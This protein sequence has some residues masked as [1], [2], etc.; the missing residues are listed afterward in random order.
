MTRRQKVNKVYSEQVS[1]KHEKEMMQSQF[2]TEG[3]ICLIGHSYLV[4]RSIPLSSSEGFDDSF[5]IFDKLA[6]TRQ[7]ARK[8]RCQQTTLVYRIQIC[9]TYSGNWHSHSSD[10]HQ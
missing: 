5:L 10:F 2:L 6:R 3:T 4:Y 7:S 8:G 9:T 1:E